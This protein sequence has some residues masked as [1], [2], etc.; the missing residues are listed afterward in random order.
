MRDIEDNQAIVVDSITADSHAISAVPI[1]NIG[2]VYPQIDLV[3]DSTN[4][5]VIDRCISIDVVHRTI[6]RIFRLWE[7]MSTADCYTC[8]RN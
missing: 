5:A 3:I 6:S 1:D 8:G 7:G 4:V 2:V